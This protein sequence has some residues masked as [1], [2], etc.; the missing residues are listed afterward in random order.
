MI[1]RLGREGH[2]DGAG[3]AQAR[4]ALQRL[5][6]SIREIKPT[7]DV[8]TRAERCLAVHALRAAD[9]LQL[10]A[11]LIWARERPQG[12]DFVSLDA[13]LCDAATREGLTILPENV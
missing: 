2:L 11:A 9:A 13:R 3:A 4:A 6:V 12:M 8:R 10:G 1:A 7:D 5:W